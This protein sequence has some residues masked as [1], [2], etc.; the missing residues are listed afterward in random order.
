MRSLG[1][2]IHKNALAVGCSLNPSGEGYY[3]SP[4]HR[5]GS[6]GYKC[7]S[8]SDESQIVVMTG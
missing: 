8:I 6:G 2:K 5:G 7:C 4:H 3:N 1:S